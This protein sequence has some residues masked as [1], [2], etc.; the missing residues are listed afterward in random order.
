MSFMFN[1]YPYDDPLAVNKITAPGVDL[2]AI[3]TCPTAIS[4][5]PTTSIMSSPSLQPSPNRKA[6]SAKSAATSMKVKNCPPTMY[7]PCASMVP[8]ISKSF[9]STQKTCC[10]SIAAGFFQSLFSQ[11]S[12][13]NSTGQ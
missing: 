5:T 6:G 4:P 13:S 2:T 11:F 3:K 10:E 1:P 9:N 8:R 7:A 12:F